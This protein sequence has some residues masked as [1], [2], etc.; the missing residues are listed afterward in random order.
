MMPSHGAISARENQSSLAEERNRS[1]GA[2]MKSVKAR[3]K[4]GRI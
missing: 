4:A 3:D 1:T 2:K